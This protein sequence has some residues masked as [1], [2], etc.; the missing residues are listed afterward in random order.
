MIRV[1]ILRWWFLPER[2]LNEDP[3]LMIGIALLAPPLA[4]HWL[5]AHLAACHYVNWPRNE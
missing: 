1:L 2:R 3:L 5:A 4:N